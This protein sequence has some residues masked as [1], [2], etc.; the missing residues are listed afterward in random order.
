MNDLMNE[1]EVAKSFLVW[2][3]DIDVSLILYIASVLY[4]YHADQP[5]FFLNHLSVSS[6]LWTLRPTRESS[7]K[8]SHD[9]TFSSWA[10]HSSSF[11]L[12]KASTSN[13]SVL[14]S[15]GS[16][17]GGLQHSSQ[18]ITASS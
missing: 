15:S 2:L 10:S 14:P 18:A 16:S 1:N 6:P 17:D 5:I 3:Y 8:A 9:L 13:G 12:R 4:L 11:F 7:E